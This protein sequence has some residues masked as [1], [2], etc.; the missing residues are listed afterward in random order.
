MMMSDSRGSDLG[1]GEMKGGLAGGSRSIENM[2]NI[3]LAPHVWRIRFRLE[4]TEQEEKYIEQYRE[5]ISQQLLAVKINLAQALAIP[6]SPYISDYNPLSV[7]AF[8]DHANFVNSNLLVPNDRPSGEGDKEQWQFMAEVYRQAL[9]QLCQN[10]RYGNIYRLAN[11]INEFD[12]PLLGYAYYMLYAACLNEGQGH[13]FWFNIDRDLLRSC[14]ERSRGWCGSE[15][16][17]ALFACCDA[18]DEMRRGLELIRSRSQ[19]PGGHDS[20][21]LHAK[22]LTGVYG[23]PLERACAPLAA[24]VVEDMTAPVAVA[25]TALDAAPAAAARAADA[26]ADV[27]RA[28]ASAADESGAAGSR[29]RPRL[30]EMDLIVDGVGDLCTASPPPCAEPDVSEVLFAAAPPPP[31]GASSGVKAT[32]DASAAQK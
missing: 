11:I 4:D 12:P 15:S 16:P 1:A 23:V 28:S 25:A 32:S 20:S 13:K 2:N 18:A 31:G 10:Q 29:K 27:A 7:D 8:S 6:N 3:I 14:Q 9:A 24:L 17:H 22:L 26:D 30:A 5:R 21:S 19:E